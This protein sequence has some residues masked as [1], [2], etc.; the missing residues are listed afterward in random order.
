MNDVASAK[1]NQ[2]ATADVGEQNQASDRVSV[3]NARQALKDAQRELEAQKKTNE[4]DL[5]R[6]SSDLDSRERRLR[7]DIAALEES[8]RQLRSGEQGR[9]AALDE[10][11]RVVKEKMG[12]NP[13]MWQAAS[14][15]R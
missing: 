14:R 11:T 10:A 3:E 4:E 1:A 8:Q 6:I 13:D 15:I 12:P 5:V 9:Q 2:A 7:E